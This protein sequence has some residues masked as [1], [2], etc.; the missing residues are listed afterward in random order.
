MSSLRTPA[1]DK[2]KKDY[3]AL[4]VLCQKQCQS[5][6]KKNRGPLTQMDHGRE[7]GCVTDIIGEEETFR[8][9]ME[10]EKYQKLVELL[11]AITE[12][13]AHQHYLHF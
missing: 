3:N 12:S 8:S 7:K 1:T 10:D 11:L 4:T 13:P 6:Y 9:N 2:L 5:K